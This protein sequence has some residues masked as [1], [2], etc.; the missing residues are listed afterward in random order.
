MPLHT[1]RR[2]LRN[3]PLIHLP[4]PRHPPL[5]LAR[6]RPVVPEGSKSPFLEAGVVEP[7][8]VVV[9]VVRQ[10]FFVLDTSLAEDGGFEGCARAVLFFEFG[11]GGVKGFGFGA[12]EAVEGELVVTVV[13]L[14]N[15]TRKVKIDAPCK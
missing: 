12:G 8:V 1:P 10:L 15:R 14:D 9:P 2:H 3:R 11:V 13:Y 4:H 7:D 5:Y 6:A